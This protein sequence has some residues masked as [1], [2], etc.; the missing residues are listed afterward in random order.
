MAKKTIYETKIKPNLALI[1]D[2]RSEGKDIQ[3]VANAIG[4][5]YNT[6]NNYMDRYE[7]FMEAWIMGEHK[8]AEKLEAAVIRSATGYKYI[9]RK[10]EEYYDSKNKFTGKKITV[11]EKEQAPN[12]QLLIKALESLRAKKWANSNK[13]KELE[14]IIDED[15]IE[16]SE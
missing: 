12:P 1:T 3:Y 2:L 11:Y 4:V 13:A 14:I 10:I 9:E 5:S 16:Y 6:F 7:D 8:I 15:L